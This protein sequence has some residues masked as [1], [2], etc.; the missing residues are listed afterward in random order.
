MTGRPYIGNKDTGDTSWMREGS[1]LGCD[2]DLFFPE[3]GS[4]TDLAAAKAIC[5]TCPVREQ[6]LDYAIRNS[7]H[8]GVWGGRSD[9]ERRRIAR[10]R[11]ARGE[12][13]RA[14]TSSAGPL[15]HGAG[16]NAYQRCRALR[17]EACTACKRGH[18]N[19]VQRGKAA[20]RERAS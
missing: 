17:G 20:R 15:I 16:T 11:R 14:S 1:C 19:D 4:M 3:R 2:P 10:E 13:P 9:K 12:L 8:T 6:C 7:E 18:A 5:A